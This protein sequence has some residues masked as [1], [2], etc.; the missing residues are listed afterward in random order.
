MLAYFLV[1]SH[2]VL[3]SNYIV[4]AHEICHSLLSIFQNIPYFL[5]SISLLFIAT[6]SICSF[7]YLINCTC[8]IKSKFYIKHGVL[9]Y[10]TNR[11]II[12]FEPI[13]HMTGSWISICFIFQLNIDWSFLYLLQTYL[14]L[15]A[16]QLSY[17]W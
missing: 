14:F 4:I 11:I 6:C 17:F 15:L 8:L 7:K 12:K 9:I 10:F 3:D 16:Q 1:E 2:D 13:Y 5:D